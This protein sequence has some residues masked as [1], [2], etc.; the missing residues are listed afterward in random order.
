MC[1]RH[2]VEPW[3]D[4]G[5]CN[6]LSFLSRRWSLRAGR[7]S[8]EW[9]EAIV[10]GPPVE[11][12][13]SHSRA[14]TQFCASEQPSGVRIILVSSCRWEHPPTS[15]WQTVTVLSGGGSPWR[16]RTQKKWQQ[17]GPQAL[18]EASLVRS[19]KQKT[20]KQWGG[21]VTVAQGRTDAFENGRR[22]SLKTRMPSQVLDINKLLT[23]LPG[24]PGSFTTIASFALQARHPIF[25]L[26]A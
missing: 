1:A 23:A 19:S 16:L 21:G 18:V 22:V 14:Q 10:C 13:A 9:K 8:L 24:A 7:A 25:L 6:F 26:L 4:K 15:E 3:K 11:G 2:Q 17:V 12:R 5:K 20:T